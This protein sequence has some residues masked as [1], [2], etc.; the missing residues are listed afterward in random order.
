MMA[1]PDVTMD[2]PKRASL[3]VYPADGV[4]GDSPCPEEG[5]GRG[6]AGEHS[7]HTWVFVAKI[8]DE[9]ISG[10]DALHANYTPMDFGCDVL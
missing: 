7:L 5:T 10:L 1:G 2:L 4:W 6:D 3:A 8:T 9:F